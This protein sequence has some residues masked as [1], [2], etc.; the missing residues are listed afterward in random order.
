LG[1][2]LKRVDAHGVEPQEYEELPEM[3]DEMFARAVFK[4]AGRP[5]SVNPRQM[6]SLRLPPEVIARW[7]ATGPGWQTRMA[8]RLE[9]TPL[10]SATGTA[11]PATRTIKGP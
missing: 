9:K 3:T 2:D 10:P 11:L 1:S 7:K 8:K 4:K 5:R 6:I